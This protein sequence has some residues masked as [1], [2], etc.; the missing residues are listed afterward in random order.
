MRERIQLLDD[1]GAEFARVAAAAES[2]S[3]PG[4]GLSWRPGRSGSRARSL[5]VS[6]ILVAVLGCMAYAVPVT[7]GAV[8]GIA[9]SLAGWV[10]GDHDTAPGRAVAPGDAAPSWFDESP[11]D[12]R[13]IAEADGVGLFVRRTEM[14]GNPTLQFGLGPGLVV[15][16][17]LEGWRHRLGERALVVLHGPA[18]FG[19]RDLLDDRGR[20]PLLGV[21][22]RDVASV[23]LQYAEGPPLVA[24]NGDGGFVLLADAWR[25]L[26]ELIAYDDTGRVRDRTDLTH[27][28][29]SYLCEREPGCPPG[30]TP[31]QP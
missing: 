9:D 5:A 13:V 4:S 19:P 8:D 31:G 12:A 15:G 16:D 25:P 14:D 17:T 18:A 10:L 26:R 20:H 3:R 24:E 28:D 23:E 27:Y 11:G 22:T 6:T 21:T 29:M 1:L 7:R 2:R 30:A